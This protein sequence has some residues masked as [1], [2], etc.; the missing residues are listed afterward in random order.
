V[1]Y[2]ESFGCY[3]GTQWF[4]LS[5]RAVDAVSHFVAENP[6]Y[7]DHYRR[8]DI[9]DE[10]FFQTIL[11]NDRSLRFVNDDKRFT[12]WPKGPHPLTLL[13][14]DFDDIVTSGNHFARKFDADVDS[15]ILDRLD[16]HLDAG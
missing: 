11:L 9:P 7:V 1:P 8:V 5:A 16:R 14:R 4:T 12:S 13:E 3:A 15:A 6:D 2:S 10:S